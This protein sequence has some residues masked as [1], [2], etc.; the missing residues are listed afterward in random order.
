MS[1]ISYLPSESPSPGGFADGTLSKVRVESQGEAGGGPESGESLAGGR[2]GCS[3]PL[4]TLTAGSLPGGLLHR[5]TH[6]MERGF[7]R[8]SMIMCAREREG[9][10]A[11]DRN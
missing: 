1:P 4:P 6:S 8:V 5:G 9:E 2:G 7:L 3:F 11:R 10:T